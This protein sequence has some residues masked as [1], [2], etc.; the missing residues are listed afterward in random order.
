MKFKTK[1]KECQLIVKVKTSSKEIVDEKEIDRFSRVFLRGFLKPKMIK[2][3][4]IEYTGPVGISLYDRMKKPISKRDFLFI[5]EQVVVRLCRC[6]R[7]W[8]MPLKLLN[9]RKT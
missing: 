8:M 4:L 9:L 2:K 7:N 5:I 6:R 1:Q 3:N